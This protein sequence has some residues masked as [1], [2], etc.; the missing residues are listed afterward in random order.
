[1][2]FEITFRIIELINIMITKIKA[3]KNNDGF[4]KYFK[5]TSWVFV[6]KI[7]RMIVGIF[8]GIWVARYLGPEQFGLFSYAQSFVGL[9]L[10]ISTL[11]LDDILVKEFL[12]SENR[13]NEIIGTAFCLKIVGALLVLIILLFAVNFTSND[14]FTN[15]LIFIIASSTI[16]QSFNVIDYYFQSKVLSKY[17]VYANIISLL[18]S[19]LV[20]IFLILNN[21]TLVS[22]AWVIVFD[23]IVLSLGFIY[24]YLKKIKLNIEIFSFKIEVAFLLLKDSW[25]LILSSMVISLYMRI[26]QVMIKEMLNN[27]SVG[28]Y[29][30]AV[31]LSEV[32]Y[33]IPG[34]IVGSILP[35]IINAKKNNEELYYKR[36][37]TLYDLMVWL[38]L[39]LSLPIIFLSDWIID[40][41]YG[42][43]YHEASIVLSIHILTSI[44]V[45][46]GV[47]S[48]KW[49]II[50]NLQ[51]LLL[52]RTLYGL[53]V[54]IVLN[55]ILIPIYGI[56]GAAI[57]TLFS[58]IISTYLSDLFSKETRRMFFMKS[59]TLLLTS[60]REKK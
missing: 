31:R 52:R 38:A 56:I 36:L 34:A 57:A 2:V 35:S 27:E 49:F 5:N 42:K 45:F 46:L 40:F 23:T 41:F 47:A 8:V 3:L 24:F 11:G 12:K 58:Q 37:Q 33:F 55:F 19:S 16:F 53:F 59:K 18:I 44:F 51:K 48:G 20:K 1:M 7:L 22:F 14:K 30:A 25:P 6:E 28:Y 15:T 54:N 60:I 50:E 26:D 21:A 10:A 9:F 13:Q 17:I 32:W 39:I 43:D 29:A 4:M